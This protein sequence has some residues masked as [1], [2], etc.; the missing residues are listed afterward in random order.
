[1]RD[2][3]GEPPDRLHFSGLVQLVVGGHLAADILKVDREAGGAGVHRHHQPGLGAQPTHLEIARMPTRHRAA[4]FGL[5]NGAGEFR[6]HIPDRVAAHILGVFAEQAVG[7]AIGADDAPFGIQ[8][9]QGVRHFEQQVGRGQPM[10]LG[11]G[12]HFMHGGLDIGQA[13]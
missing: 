1:M 13:P 2:P 5:E 9:E 12:I 3:P 7:V 10:L 6:E 11:N 8:R 4:A